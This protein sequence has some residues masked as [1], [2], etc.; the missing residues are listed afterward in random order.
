MNS[1]Q[2]VGAVQTQPNPDTALQVRLWLLQRISAAVLAPLVLGHLL[3]II[4][5]VH[6][7]LSAQAILGRLHDNAL[8]GG[9]YTLFV[10][11]CAAHVPVGIAR[12]AEEWLGWRARPA[13]LLGA[14]LALAL[15]LG[16][17]RAV[18][19]VVWA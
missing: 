16:G 10:L 8:L 13:L 5:A 1:V 4:Y 7:G 11:A 3:M 9:F 14:L 19:G 12:I 15:L 17:L 18:W 2:E 6:Q